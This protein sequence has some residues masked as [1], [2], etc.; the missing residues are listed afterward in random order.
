VKSDPTSRHFRVIPLVWAPAT[1]SRETRGEAGGAAEVARR[2]PVGTFVDYGEPIESTAAIL[3]PYYTFKAKRTSFHLNVFAPETMDYLRRS[4]RRRHLMRWTHRGR[5][6][7]LRPRYGARRPICE[8]AL[9]IA[10]SS[11]STSCRERT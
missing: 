10:L 6:I 11:G 7:W 4:M 2:F 1:I 8:P 5:P 9:P 3:T